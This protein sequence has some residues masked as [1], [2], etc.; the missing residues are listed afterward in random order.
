MVS[1]EKSLRFG[2][3][4]EFLIVW[5]AAQTGQLKV[6]IQIR[7]ALESFKNAQNR[8]SFAKSVSDVLRRKCTC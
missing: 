8:L 5:V 2:T 3:A 1:V 7:K 4:K 6:K